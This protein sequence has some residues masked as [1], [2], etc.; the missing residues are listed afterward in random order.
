[1]RLRPVCLRPPSSPARL[2]TPSDCG[3]PTRPPRTET[4]TATWDNNTTVCKHT[5]VCTASWVTSCLSFRTCWGF[6]MWGR[7]RSTCRLRGGSPPGPTGRPGSE[8]WVSV[9]TGS[10]WQPETAVETC[11]KRR[12]NTPRW[13][14]AG[15]WRG[16]LTCLC[17]FRI[18]GLEFLDELVKIEAHDSEVLC[19]AFSPTSTGKTSGSNRAQ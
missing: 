16:R 7:T 2:I 1:M 10:T 8:F 11:G 13:S 6:C 17:V 14:S 19:L 18:F 4:S 9:L 12:R 5:A 15:V 3:T